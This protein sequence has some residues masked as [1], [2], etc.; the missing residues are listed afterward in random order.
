MEK[1]SNNESNEVDNLF[2]ILSFTSL[3]QKEIEKRQNSYI[4]TPEHN[5][6]QEEEPQSVSRM[7]TIRCICNVDN[8][9]NGSSLVQ[10]RNCHY[11]LHESCMKKIQYNTNNLFCPFCRLTQNGV[12]QF[13]ELKEYIKTVENEIKTVHDMLDEASIIEQQYYQAMGNKIFTTDSS[14]YQKQLKEKMSQIQ[15]QNET[16][17][18]K[19]INYF[20]NE[21]TPSETEQS[22]SGEE[23]NTENQEQ[24]ESSEP[25]P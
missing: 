1:S 4:E 18:N 7:K 16:F 12:D 20:E 2:Q 9:L 19:T 11:F 5:N 21:S 3:I 23:S 6:E 17:L 8:Q 15:V 13:T 24:D 10:C 14:K 25:S 22:E